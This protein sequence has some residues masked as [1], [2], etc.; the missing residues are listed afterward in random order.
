MVI[1]N[2][3]AGTEKS[4][5]KG[6]KGKDAKSAEELLCVLRRV[7]FAP[8]AFKCFSPVPSAQSKLAALLL[9]EHAAESAEHVSGF[10]GY[11]I[12]GAPQRARAAVERVID[13]TG[14]RRGQSLLQESDDRVDRRPGFV[15]GNACPLGNLFDQLIHFLLL[16]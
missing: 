11:R 16:L 15:F 9:A 3:L 6:R 5:R 13:L 14:N 8:F 1:K 7:S 12:T 10:V 2:P 4:E